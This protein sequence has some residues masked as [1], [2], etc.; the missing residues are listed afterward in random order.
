MGVT[1]G[2]GFRFLKGLSW[3]ISAR[4]YHGF[5]NVYKSKSGTNNSS[6]FLKANIPFG[7]S[8]EKKNE[9]KEMKAGL[10]K[11]KEEKKVA[12]KKNKEK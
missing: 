3:T 10:L 8:E 4:Y 11:V 12:R 6:F 1:G 9:I 7:V 2:V 5:T